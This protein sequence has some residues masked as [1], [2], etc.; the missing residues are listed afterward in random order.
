LRH[1]PKTVAVLSLIAVAIAALAFVPA[2]FEIRA[3]G[4]LVPTNY[5]HLFA[6]ADGVI[7]RLHV[8]HAESV[9]AGTPLL[10]MRR[11]DLDFE[12]ARLLGDILTNQ[13]RLDAVRSALLNHK[14]TSVSSASEFHDLT[15]EEARLQIL[16]SSLRDQQAIL[17]RERA[18]LAITSPIDGEVLTWGVKDV[19]SLRPV[20]RGERLL[21]V[22]DPNG[23]WQLDLQ[24]ADHDIEYVLA[25]RSE[26]E[27]LSVSFILTSRSGEG[28]RGIVEEIAMATELDEHDQ[29]TV[30]VRV[31]VDCEQLPELRPG[32]TVIAN[33][34]CGRRSIGY[35]WLRELFDVIKTRL[36][37]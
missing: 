32:A 5:R 18:E 36:L 31:A 24:I 28:Y 14:S 16:L 15:S 12:E 7:E 23:P 9:T 6:P 22:A 33:V 27:E 10:D 2:D 3:E 1:L 17:E 8:H 29:P 30:L 20:R 35:V 13:K 34:Y 37:F 11:T 19:L 26:L 25:A 4:Q 21:S